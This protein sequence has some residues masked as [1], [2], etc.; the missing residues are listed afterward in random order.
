M[1]DLFVFTISLENTKTGEVAPSMIVRKATEV[2]A[3]EYAEDAIANHP[4]LRV[5]SIASR[6]A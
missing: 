3:R 5:H 2:E 1:T 4:D 6:P